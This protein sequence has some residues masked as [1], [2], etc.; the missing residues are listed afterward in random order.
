MK[1]HLHYVARRVGGPLQMEIDMLKDFYSWDS[2]D[3]NE[4][5]FKRLLAVQAALEIAKA[6]VSATTSSVGG[7]VENDINSVASSIEALSDAI[8]KVLEVKPEEE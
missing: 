1:P 5:K 3:M 4:V 2:T 7:N 8:L 6:R